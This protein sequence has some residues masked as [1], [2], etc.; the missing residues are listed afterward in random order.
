MRTW[1]RAR[2]VLAIPLFAAV[3]SAAPASAR[4][5][6]PSAEATRDAGKHFQRGVAL[7]NEADYAGA[8]VEFKRAHE[9]APN[10]AVLYNIG[11]TN[12][13]LRSYAAA[14]TA[15]ERYIAEA[16]SGAEHR[17][18]AQASVETLRSRVGKIDVVAP[19]GAEIMIDDELAGR[20]PLPPILAAVGKR[21][22]VASKDGRSSSPRYIDISAGETVKTELKIEEAARTQAT[23]VAPLTS[24]PAEVTTRS[25]GA[26]PVVLWVTAGALAAGGIATGVV[27]LSASTDLEDERRKFPSSRAAL[28]HDKDRAQTFG[29]VTDILLGA[30]ILTAGAALY[31]TLT[32]SR[33]TVGRLPPRTAD[34]VRFR[35]GPSGA[36]I[37]GTF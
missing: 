3:L 23:M 34:A 21:K 6:A 36:A 1:P 35:M 20:A 11:Q 18:E 31:F 17:S 8:L 25:R 32:K 28:D 30:S 13:Q 37:G 29:L 14:L 4:A 33:S 22:L 26:L 24:P 19:D 15:F 10:P 12:F 9:I 2:F 7:F 27:A 5:D 16:G